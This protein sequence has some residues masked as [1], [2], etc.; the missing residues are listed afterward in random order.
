[1]N[2]VG[3]I[4]TLVA[5]DPAYIRAQLPRLAFLF[6]HYHQAHV[7]GLH[8]IPKG[9]A[10]VVGNH[11][12]GVMA[13]DM[14]AFMLAYWRERGA[15]SPSYGLMHDVPFRVP[16]FGTAMARL[17][18]VPARPSHAHA[19]LA[20]EAHV[21]VYPGGDLDAFKSWT[22]RHE[23]IFGE[24][25]GFVRVALRARAPIVPVVSI[26]AHEGCWVLTDGAEF[27][28]RSGLKRWTR[29][30]VLPIVVGLPWFCWIGPVPYLPL[31]LRM[32]LRVLP[33]IA[34]PDLGPEAADDEAI[35]RR[36][37]DEVRVRMQDA[38]DT[39]VR[40]RGGQFRWPLTSRVTRP[41]LR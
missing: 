20:R 10:L 5:R 26:G 38:L 23:I 14:W 12:G 21:L 25:L 3:P 15:D 39:L 36:C 27:A 40:E 17:G 33:Q 29:M 35:V 34:W 32:K 37:R 28:R 41:R 4:G 7:E 8:H 11:N 2:L 1:M 13:P 31:P 16:L 6:D 19:L 18:A 30:E 24:R 22:R 9:R